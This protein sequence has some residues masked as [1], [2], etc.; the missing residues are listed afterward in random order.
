MKI[1]GLTGG[2]GS[3]KSTV[4]EMFKEQGI[5][6]Y[7]ADIEAKKIMHTSKDVI[8]KVTELFGKESY[9]DG[10]LNRNFIAE[11]VFNN[12]EKLAA[13]NGIV[14]PAVHQHFQSFCT[15][16]KAAYLVYESAVLFENNSEN[17]CDV[18]VLVVAPEKVRIQRVLARE[19]ISRAQVEARINNQLSDAE[20]IKKA[21]F[22]IS[23]ME[24]ENTKKEVLRIHK[25]LLNSSRN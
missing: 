2:I 1:V 24:L 14:H 11:I 18:I 25:L 20:K 10:V 12:K 23:N 3:G 4:L 9:N 19:N 7:I 6:V 16:Q 22:V 8:S 15:K 5:P 17:I 13:L 21:D